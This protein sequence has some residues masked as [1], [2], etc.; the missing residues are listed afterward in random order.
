MSERLEKK[1]W[2]LK[3]SVLIKGPYLI[4]LFYS[5]L[6]VIGLLKVDRLH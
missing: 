5:N 1:M 6:L 2:V 3:I 4:I